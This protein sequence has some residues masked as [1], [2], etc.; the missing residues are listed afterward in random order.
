MTDVPLL[1]HLESRIRSVEKQIDTSNHILEKRLEL[2]N[3]FREALK[4]QANRSPS[5]AEIDIKLAAIDKDIRTLMQFMDNQHGK[6]SVQEVNVARTIAYIGLVL[7]L[8][9]L[10]SRFI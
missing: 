3:E 9:S 2:M 7:S 10:L 5:R 4:D 8:L 6:A 1:D